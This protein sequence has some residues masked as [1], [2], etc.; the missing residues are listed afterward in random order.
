ML[1]LTDELSLDQQK[2]IVWPIFWELTFHIRAHL[3]NHQVI[4]Q[5]MSGIET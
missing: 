2:V 3:S 4:P 5:L 1:P